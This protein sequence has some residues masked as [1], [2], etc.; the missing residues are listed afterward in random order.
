MK[1][2]LFISVAFFGGLFTAEGQTPAA[3]DDVCRAIGAGSVAELAAIMDE[4]VELSILDQENLYSRADAKQ[5]LTAFFE[6]HTP[7]SFGK[8]HYGLSKGKDAEYC[9][10]TLVTAKGSFRVYIYVEKTAGGVL[11]QE[12][13]FDRS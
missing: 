9:I 12:L 10:G 5:A 8:V 11:L 13:K 1:S 6:Q 4:E 3:L 7:T 2:I